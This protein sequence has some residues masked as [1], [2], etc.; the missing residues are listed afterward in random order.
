MSKPEKAHNQ[1]YDD[2]NTISDIALD[3]LGPIHVI[4]T[5]LDFFLTQAYKSAPSSEEAEI[6]INAS[7]KRAKE[8]NN[9]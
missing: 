8:E 3:H 5:G 1:L 9:G 6:L 2:L 7:V 4:A